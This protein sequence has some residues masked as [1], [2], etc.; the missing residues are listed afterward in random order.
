[1]IDVME[2]QKA[3]AIKSNINYQGTHVI[4]SARKKTM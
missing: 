3:T 1:M 2:H 4:A